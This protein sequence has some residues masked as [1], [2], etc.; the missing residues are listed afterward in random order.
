MLRR[1]SSANRAVFYL[2][3]YRS[4][5]LLA[6]RSAASINMQELVDVHSLAWTM[7]VAH[8]VVIP[9]DICQVS[10]LI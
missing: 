7:C 1:R 5:F 8:L 10:T 4:T 2:V 3:A 9:G 6:C